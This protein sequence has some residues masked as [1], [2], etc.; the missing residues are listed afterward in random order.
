MKI[1]MVRTDSVSHTVAVFV[2]SHKNK[3]FSEIILK[4]GS[5]QW[6]FK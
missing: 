4:N 1:A 5:S 2:I 3:I 6:L